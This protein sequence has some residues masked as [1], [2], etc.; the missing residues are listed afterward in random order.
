[1]MKIAGSQLFQIRTVDSTFPA[2]GTTNGRRPGHWIFLIV[3]LL[4]VGLQVL[5]SQ[6]RPRAL[7]TLQRF[8]PVTNENVLLEGVGGLGSVFAALMRTLVNPQV[9]LQMDLRMGGQ[10]GFFHARIRAGRLI[11]LKQFD[12]RM[13]PDVDGHSRRRPR[14]VGT[15][16][17]RAL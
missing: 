10:V 11:A 16:V 3:L 15:A 12:A 9:R 5:G 14:P 1:M 8:E 2:H 6:I 4:Q 7:W 17:Q 13:S